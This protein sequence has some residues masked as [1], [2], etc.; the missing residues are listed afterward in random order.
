MI[1]DLASPTPTPSAGALI[2]IPSHMPA[3]WQPSGGRKRLFFTVS[4]GH[5]GTMMLTRA[6]KCAYNVTSHHE[7]PPAVVQFPAVMRRGLKATY[8]RR[9]QEKLSVFLD[10]VTRTGD[11][12]YADISHMMT[13]SWADVA[14]DWLLQDPR[15]EITF[16]VLRR[17]LPHVL[18]SFLLVDVWRPDSMLAFNGGE[19][20]LFHRGIAR[21]PP[22]KP[23]HEHDSADLVMG[24]LIDQEVQLAR[25]KQRYA[26]LGDRI[27]FVDVRAEDLFSRGGVRRL[28]AMLGLPANEKALA[29]IA[30][31]TPVNQH[32][33]WRAP[34]M[35]NISDSTYLAR[36][37]RAVH[38]YRDRGVPLPPMPHLAQMAPCAAMGFEARAV[39]AA[40]MAA[41]TG[42]VGRGTSAESGD[43]GAPASGFGGVPKAMFDL[44]GRDVLGSAAAPVA[45]APAPGGNLVDGEGKAWIPPTL[46]G[47]SA[48]MRGSLI[49]AAA[50][51]EPDADMMCVR[52]YTEMSAADI[53]RE[54]A[55]LTIPHNRPPVSKE[56]WE[57]NR[58]KELPIFTR[59]DAVYGSPGPE[60]LAE[61]AANE[62]EAAAFLKGA[63]DSV[64]A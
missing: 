38:E 7:A 29:A 49:V 1:G 39:H 27:R 17:W 48:G 15:Y 58:A 19:Y 41:D 32:V 4:S 34:E 28:L 8:A 60:E 21:L 30:T 64:A 53:E 25:M 51:G 10:W 40:A 26:S 52:P 13:K 42:A 57:A 62:A 33:S 61:Q 2:P 44:L 36:V 20:S 59:K 56:V 46:A 24:H 31:T 5:S 6:L 18:R 16:V 50:R 47:N 37:Q 35:L 12:P 23:Y 9:Q 11:H 55:G 54:L 45:A 43:I 63:K 3:E 22:L 14:L